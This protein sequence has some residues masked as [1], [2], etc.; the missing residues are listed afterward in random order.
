MP[1]PKP[2]KQAIVFV[3]ITLLLDTIGFGLI[4]P[5]LPTLLA[6]ITGRDVSR[7]PPGHHL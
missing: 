7:G 1:P 5:V 2:D 3:A 6:E 4:V